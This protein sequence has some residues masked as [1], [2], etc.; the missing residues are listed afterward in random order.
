MNF[1]FLADEAFTL[2]QNILKPYAQRELTHEKKS[3]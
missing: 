3:V 2:S 1:V